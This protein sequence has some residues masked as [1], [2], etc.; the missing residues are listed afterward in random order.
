MEILQQLTQLIVTI[1]NIVKF[2]SIAS[3]IAF[4]TWGG[5]RIINI[6]EGKEEREID[7]QRIREETERVGFYMQRSMYG[8]KG[9]SQ[10]FID[11]DENYEESNESW[12]EEEPEWTPWEMDDEDNPF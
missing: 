6:L 9:R 2:V 5:L 12:T 8:G 11:F 4:A 10:S 3:V 1:T 7:I